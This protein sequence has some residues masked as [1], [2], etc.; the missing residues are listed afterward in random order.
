[1]T[2]GAAMYVIGAGNG[3]QL[4]IERVSPSTLRKLNDSLPAFDSGLRT[5]GGLPTSSAKTNS[6]HM[7]M[8]AAP[9]STLDAVI[10]VQVA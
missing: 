8:H 10:L 9:T 1:M 3:I 2:L 7:P 6:G 5:Q 4:E